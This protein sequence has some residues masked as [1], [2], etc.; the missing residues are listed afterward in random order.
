MDEVRAMNEIEV[1][2]SQEKIDFINDAYQKELQCSKKVALESVLT[3]NRRNQLTDLAPLRVFLARKAAIK[4][5]KNVH[6]IILNLKSQY[7]T[8]NEEQIIFIQDILSQEDIHSFEAITD[9]LKTFSKCIKEDENMNL[10]NKVLFGGWISTAWKAYR[11]EKFMGEKNLPRRFEDRIY[12][13]C[14][15]KKQTTYNY[16]NLYKLMSVAAKLLN[17]R[18]NMTYFVKNHEILFT[19]FEENEE[20][21]S[22]KHK[23]YCACKDCISHF[24]EESTHNMYI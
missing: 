1:N 2:L 14:G 17:C 18:V 9:Y 7:L 3:K 4:N 5:V 16:K 6:E 11:Q 22:W 10:K 23:F 21:I 15:I 8:H 19:Y 20:Q 13:E 12:R 24:F